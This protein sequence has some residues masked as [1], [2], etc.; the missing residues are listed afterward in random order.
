[1]HACCAKR[2]E[3]A[4]LILLTL[5]VCP[6]CAATKSI[7]YGEKRKERMATPTARQSKDKPKLFAYFICGFDLRSSG[8][9]RIGPPTQRQRGS[10]IGS[11]TSCRNMTSNMTFSTTKRRQTL[12]NES[13]HPQE[14]IHCYNFAIQWKLPGV[15]ANISRCSARRKAPILADRGARQPPQKGGERS[16]AK[17]Y[18]PPCTRRSC[19]EPHLPPWLRLFVLVPTERGKRDTLLPAPNVSSGRAED[20]L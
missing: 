11:S 16:A 12:K 13:I 2:D 6:P 15:R 19:C 3:V 17:L 5:P 20:H 14:T 10:L 8:N 1:M 4:C 18:S 7:L 9:N